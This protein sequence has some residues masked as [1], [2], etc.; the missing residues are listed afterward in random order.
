MGLEFIPTPFLLVGT[1]LSLSGE[2]S[3]TGGNP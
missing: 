2:T 1:L 3:Y